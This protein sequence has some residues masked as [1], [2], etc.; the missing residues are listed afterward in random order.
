MRTRLFKLFFV[1][2]SAVT[3]ISTGSILP[4]E[5]QADATPPYR[6]LNEPSAHSA[7]KVRMEIFVDFYCPHCHHFEATV[8]PELK[9][10]FGDKL[11]VINV[12]FPVIR[13]QP[14]MPF[15]LYEAAREEGRGN[16]MA[17]VLFRV[18]QDERLNILD[19]SVEEKVIQE[20][21][22]NPDAMKKRLASGGPKRKL[23][24]GVSRGNRYGVNSTPTVL[25]DGYVLSEVP[26]AENLRPLVQKLL[27]GERL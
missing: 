3:A 1:I 20:A 21:G 8:L 17:G 4:V 13:N 5:I 16:V 14:S 7:G 26:T 10:E 19:P 15:E 9:R 2:F 25:L 11:E 23:E 24:E 27:S 22:V 12:G 6:I 18:L